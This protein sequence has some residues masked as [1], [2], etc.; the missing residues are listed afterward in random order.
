MTI[1]TLIEEVTRIDVERKRIRESDRRL[2]ERKRLLERQIYDYLDK[3]NTPGIRYKGKEYTLDIKTNRNRL[4]KS[5][6]EQ[7]SKDI[8]RKYGIHNSDD[9]VDEILDSLKGE[10]STKRILKVKSN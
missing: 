8:L 9:I 7:I 1:Q 5:E 4:K 10:Q 3:T 2:I 6:K